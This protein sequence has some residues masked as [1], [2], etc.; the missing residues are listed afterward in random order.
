MGAPS[1]GAD[2][3]GL[4]YFINHV[5]A[6]SVV[7][8]NDGYEFRSLLAIRVMVSYSFPFALSWPLTTVR[9]LVG[10]WCA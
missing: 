8:S 2:G 5:P 1:P 6:H 4:G 3:F 10:S 9:P 7:Q